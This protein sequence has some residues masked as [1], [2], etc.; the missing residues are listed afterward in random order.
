MVKFLPSFL[1]YSPIALRH[2]LNDVYKNLNLYL[3]LINQEI[4]SFHID[5]VAE[6]FAKDRKVMMRVLEIQNAC[7]LFT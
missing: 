6:Q 7:K 2:K 3:K 5:I 1:D 4:P